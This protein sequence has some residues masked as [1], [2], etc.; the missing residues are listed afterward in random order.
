M[1]LEGKVAIVT[2]GTLG[3]GEAIA[4]EFAVEG[5]NVII[6]RKLVNPLKR[7]L[8]VFCYRLGEQQPLG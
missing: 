3:I 8:K 6:K 7:T 5:A 2:G 1:R 4:K